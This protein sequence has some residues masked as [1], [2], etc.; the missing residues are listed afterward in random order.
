MDLPLP[1]NT[2]LIEDLAGATAALIRAIETD[3]PDIEAALRRRQDAIVALSQGLEQL[4]ADARERIR[5]VSLRG[6]EVHAAVRHQRA[7]IV[8]ALLENQER[9]RQLHHLADADDMGSIIK[10]DA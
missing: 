9:L 1:K 2:S 7:E 8:R 6:L 4:P 10:L 3:S 5:Q